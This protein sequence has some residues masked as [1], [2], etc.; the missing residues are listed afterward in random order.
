MASLLSKGTSSFIFGTDLL[1]QRDD[2]NLYLSSLLNLYHLTGNIKN[3][4]SSLIPLI[5]GANQIGAIHMGINGN[6]NINNNN[7]NQNEDKPKLCL[8]FEDGTEAASIENNNDINNAE[9]KV[10]FTNKKEYLNNDYDLI[11]PVTDFSSRAGTYINLENRIQ[12]TNSSVNTKNDVKEVWQIIND[13]SKKLKFPEIDFQNKNEIFK[14]IS[15]NINGFA[16]I[17]YDNL[18]NESTMINNRI[19][20]SFIIQNYSSN[21]KQEK[22]RLYQ[23]R[24]LIKDSEDIDIIK[25]GDMNEVNVKTIL[26]ISNDILNRFGIKQGA[27]VKL[28][29]SSGYEIKGKVKILNNLNNS[30]SVTNLFGEMAIEMQD[31]KDKDWSMN[32]PK[33]DYEIIDNIK[34]E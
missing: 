19:A 23:G 4:K 8:I 33:L 16:L 6:Q 1:N 28:I 32:I 31:S 29:C 20:P 22:I 25:N 18:K 15:K 5:N 2:K 14:D 24:V 9:V 11:F 30:V 17:D 10:L 7:E 34:V 12:Y 13:I 21:E 3:E 26:E 27:L